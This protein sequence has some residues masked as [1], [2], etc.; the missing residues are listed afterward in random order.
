MRWALLLA[1]ALSACRHLPA[2]GEPELLAVSNLTVAFPRQEQGDLFFEV[3][4][5][6]EVVRVASLKW[7]LTLGGRRFAEGLVMT[8]DVQQDAGGIRRVRIEAPLVYRHVSWRDGS[9]WLQLQLSG[10]VQPFG[11]APRLSFQTRREVLV[12]AAPVLD[13]RVE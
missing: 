10:E 13:D 6:P 1:L 12:S 8:P 2:A 3:T 5:P 4:V 11:V 7:V 9:T